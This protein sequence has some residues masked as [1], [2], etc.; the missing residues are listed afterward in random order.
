MG[1]RGELVAAARSRAH[2][3]HP[4]MDKFRRAFSVDDHRVC[5][6]LTP[7]RGPSLHR[8]ARFAATQHFTQRTSQE[9]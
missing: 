1:G 5:F 2:T 6:S 4:D 7:D 9:R 3:R 8:T